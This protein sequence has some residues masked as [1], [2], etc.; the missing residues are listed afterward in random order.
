M[1]PTKLELQG[2]TSFRERCEID[3]GSFDLFA[4]TGQTGAGKTSLLDAMTYALYGKTSR[5]N[6]AG[7]DLISQGAASMSVSLC[8]RAGTD[9]YRV[10]RAIHGSTVTARLE[11]L[12]RG[13]WRSVSGNVGEIG[14]LVERV[15]GL[16]FDAFTK[17]VIL[18]QGRFDQFLRGSRKEQRETLNDLL[19]M[20]VYQRMVQSAN[21]EKDIAAKL[22]AA[23]QAE[24]DPAATDEA[25]AEYE[26]EL[27]GLSADE[28]CAADA[29]GR[30]HQALPHALMLREKRRA[31][32][33]SE[34]DLKVSETRM[35]GAEAAAANARRELANRQGAVEA[36]CRE[37]AALEYDGE[38]HVRLARIEQKAIQRQTLVGDLAHQQRKRC[39][40]ESK[41]AAS[42]AAVKSA[43]ESRA[44]A[45][46][47]LGKTEESRKS[48]STAFSDLRSRHG[49]ADTVQHAAGELDKSRSGEGEIRKQREA[50]AA[51]EA[52]ATASLV[53]YEAA[54]RAVAEAETEVESARG[55]YEHWLARDRVADLRHD[56]RVGDPCPVCE[57]TVH[58]APTPLCARELVMARDRCGV[59][60][61]ALQ[62]RRDVLAALLAETAVLPGRIDLARGK[63]ELM[64]SAVGSAVERASRIL[65]KPADKDAA[66]LLR[67]LSER[68]RAAESD[69][70]ETQSGYERALTVERN[71]SQALED[72]RH[73][74]K[75]ISSQIGNIDDRTIALR[76]DIDRLQED[77]AGAPPLEEVATCLSALNNARQR[78]A[79][80]EASMSQRRDELKQAEE[81]AIRCA[82]DVEALQNIQVK[83]A[84]Q[85]EELELEIGRLAAQV[86]R[87][88]GVEARDS[89]DEA[90]RIE[91]ARAAGQKDLETVQARVQ[92][93]RFAIQATDEKI[94]RNQRL[95]EEIAWCKAREAMY[96]DLGTWLN[97]SNFQQYLM[98]SAFELLAHKGSSHLRELS[99]GRSLLSKLG[100]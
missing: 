84:A 75:L 13:R 42:Q 36:L 100:E 96:R 99:D 10:C 86:G 93:L 11:R 60:E 76:Q 53:E 73:N 7:K 59:A 35:A 39:A 83:C 89:Q 69:A 85:I 70:L 65:G 48:A 1:R 17:S 44:G 78:S 9:D 98:N 38:S 24:L 32:Q 90:G 6:K 12:E 56:L 88:G 20:Q 58:S 51:L 50:L 64:E 40:E 46:A 29:L 47:R 63:C 4:I 52:R 67:A 25:K 71:A 82:K 19:Q 91:S 74:W 54:I 15:I 79:G 77:L 66:G 2:F 14:Q 21:T 95:R 8:F 34:Q 55:R 57:Q 81:S 94:V 37:I 22:T 18:P 27:A 68:I 3:F 31:R 33:A 80:L 45:V 5:L 41:L 43:E 97:A 16:D 61:A 49:S 87:I 72:A 62:R 30:L 28:E 23:K 26:R 92:R